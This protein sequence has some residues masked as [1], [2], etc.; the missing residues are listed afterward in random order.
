MISVLYQFILN[1]LIH[2]IESILDVV[3]CSSWHILYDFR[4]FVSNGK[5]LLKNKDI[6][7]KVEWVLLDLR[8]EKVYPSFSAL[9]SISSYLQILIKLVCDLAPLLG[10]VL[11]N[12]PDKLFIL[13]LDPITLLYG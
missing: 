3:F 11:S 8:I 1:I 5:T 9:L 6:L 12:K 2:H 13:S 4:P 10:T 7:R